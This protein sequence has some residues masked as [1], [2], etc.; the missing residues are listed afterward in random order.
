MGTTPSGARPELD[1]ILQTIR[2]VEV[3]L[4]RRAARAQGSLILIW[5]LVSAVIFGFYQ[6]VESNPAPYRNAFG[7]WLGWLWI[8]PLALGY[9]ASAVVGARLGRMGADAHRQRD[10][11]RTLLP[12]LAIGA[13]AATLVV[14][15]T[16]DLIAGGATLL[17]GVFFLAFAWPPGATPVSRVCWWIGVPLIALGAWMLVFPQPWSSGAAAV[18]FAVGFGILGTVKY[19]LG[20]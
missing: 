1:A 8:V 6:L 18:A 2:E 14:T 17:A 12:G 15:G 16:T 20:R 4:E 13:L 7:A 5:G 11:R 3:S 19:R 9:V 10:F